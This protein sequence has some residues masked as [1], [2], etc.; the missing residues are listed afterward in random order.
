MIT[1]QHILFILLFLASYSPLSYF[2]KRDAWIQVQADLF[3]STAAK[4]ITSFQD[5]A[6]I[7]WR[8]RK[9]TPNEV[10]MR[11]TNKKK[12]NQQIR[13]ARARED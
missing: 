12:M 7:E 11:F 1:R 10:E 13:A 2:N 9:K 4:S 5:K 3:L 6:H 8:N